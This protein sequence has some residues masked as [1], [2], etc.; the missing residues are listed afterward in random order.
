MEHLERRSMS[1]DQIDTLNIVIL[2]ISILSVTGAGWI[3]VS[4]IVCSLDFILYCPTLLT[5]LAV[6]ISKDFQTPID[7]VGNFLPFTSNLLPT[8]TAASLPATSLWR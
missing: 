5:V 6:Q 4:F 8:S 3:I 1:G 2:I 7:P